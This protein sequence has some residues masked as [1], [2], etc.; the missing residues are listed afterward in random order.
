[1]PISR[2]RSVTV[3]IM[4]FIMPIPPTMR[5]IPAIPP[6]SIDSTDVTLLILGT[7]VFSGCGELEEVVFPD[8]FMA[9]GIADFAYCPKLSRLKLPAALQSI[10][11]GTFIG[12]ESLRAAALPDGLE[13][14]C[15]MA[16]WESGLE[17]I[18]VPASVKRI[19]ESAFWSCESLRRADVF[20]KDTFI[21]TDAFGSCYKLAEGY[22][23][24]GFPQQDGSPAAELLYSL[25]WCSCPERHSAQTSARALA[26]IGKDEALIMSRA[27][28]LCFMNARRRSSVSLRSLSSFKGK[29]SLQV[30]A[31]PQGR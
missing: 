13:E 16:F 10:G 6:R 9:I 25:L 8:G 1:M 22:I 24:P 20:G 2:V 30:T 27:R 21:G 26:F 19:G 31:V 17:R 12:C 28:L 29:A 14:I 15:D 5:E 11:E 4:M 7:E 3:T 18:S 23:A